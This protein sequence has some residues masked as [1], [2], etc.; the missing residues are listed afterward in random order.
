MPTASAP[1]GI[2]LVIAGVWLGLQ[3]LIGKLPDRIIGSTSSGPATTKS[4]ISG[5][6]SKP[7]TSNPLVTGLLPSLI[8][9]SPTLG[10]SGTSPSGGL[11]A[12]GS[13][14]PDGPAQTETPQQQASGQGLA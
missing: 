6:L 9:T 3:T 5:V 11:P 2:L 7:T 13:T 8:P 1:S 12:A 4:Q 14:L 10:A